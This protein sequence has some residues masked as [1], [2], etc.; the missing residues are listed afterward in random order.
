MER[1]RFAVELELAKDMSSLSLIRIT[2]RPA[3]MSIVAPISHK[4][5]TKGS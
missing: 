4:K 1:L 3:R 5:S 2:R